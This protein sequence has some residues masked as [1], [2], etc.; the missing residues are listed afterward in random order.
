MTLEDVERIGRHWLRSPPLRVY[1]RAIAGALGVKF[2]DPDHAP[3]PMGERE[4]LMLLQA[5]GGR[6]PEWAT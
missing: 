2:P 5:T 1:V 6:V 3:R 4:A